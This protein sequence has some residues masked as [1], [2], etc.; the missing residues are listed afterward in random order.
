M[1]ADTELILYSDSV[2]GG[3]GTSWGESSDN[4]F[5]AGILT[6]QDIDILTYNG[7]YRSGGTWTRTIGNGDNKSYS[8]TFNATQYKVTNNTEIV[9]SVTSFVGQVIYQVT[10][11]LSEYSAYYVNSLADSWYR[12]TS[13]D[14]YLSTG[15]FSPDV[16]IGYDTNFNGNN[17]ASWLV[18]TGQAIITNNPIADFMSLEIGGV[19]LWYL[20][21]GGGIMIYVSWTLVKWLL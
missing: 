15:S 8:Y 14:L 7:T 21:V 19:S 9:R 20:L 16:D 2:G 5:Y 12:M 4:T 1:I 3:G 6:A 13:S 18:S 11:S 10:C 17:W